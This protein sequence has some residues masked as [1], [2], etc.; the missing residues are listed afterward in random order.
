MSAKTVDYADSSVP[1]AI[2][3]ATIVMRNPL[4]GLYRLGS[5]NDITRGM[6]SLGATRPADKCQSPFSRKNSGFRHLKGLST[7]V[8]PYAEMTSSFP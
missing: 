1:P 3:F 8:A 4:R 7:F 6:E 2:H 5:A